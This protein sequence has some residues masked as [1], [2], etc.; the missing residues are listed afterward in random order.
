MKTMKIILEAI[1]HGGFPAIIM[2]DQ[3]RQH[4]IF[5]NKF[6]ERIGKEQTWEFH[7]D[8]FTQKRTI[9]PKED[10][11]R[12]GDRHFSYSAVRGVIIFRS[13]ILNGINTEKEFDKEYMKFY[14]EMKDVLDY[15]VK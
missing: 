7:E 13:M 3:F 6:L 14:D 8:C 11:A 2:F 15:Q 9:H 1:P 5:P 4:V 10:I 12:T